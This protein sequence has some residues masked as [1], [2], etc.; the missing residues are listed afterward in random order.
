[1]TQ[2]ER[3]G[4]CTVFLYFAVWV[5]LIVAKVFGVI[6]WGW[7][8]VIFFPLWFPLMISLIA[9]VAVIV[10][11]VICG[12]VALVIIMLTALTVTLLD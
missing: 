6:S 12:I 10:A 7:L 1:M 4:G 5:A 2:D 11:T 8:T 3:T 9:L